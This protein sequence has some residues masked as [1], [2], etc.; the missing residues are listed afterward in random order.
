VVKK[1]AAHRNAV[2]FRPIV[3]ASGYF[4]YV[5]CMWLLLVLFGLLIVA[6]LN[7]LAAA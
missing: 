6:A 5:G 1:S 4:G 7:V 2:F 3:V